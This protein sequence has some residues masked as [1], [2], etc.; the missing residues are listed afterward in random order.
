MSELG[1]RLKNAREEKGYSLDELQVRTKIQ[2]RYLA[3]IEEGDYSRL[4][5]DFYARAFIKSYADAVGLDSEMLFE[6]HRDELPQVKQ[7]PVEIPSRISRSKPKVIKK[8]SKFTSFLP[9]LIVGIFI[10]AIAV[11][12]WYLNQEADNDSSGISRENLQS[13]PN[14]ENA[15]TIDDDVNENEEEEGNQVVDGNKDEENGENQQEE[16]EQ[17]EP[18][19]EYVNTEGSTSYY[20]LS[21]TDTIDVVMNFT[22]QSWVRILDESDSSIH[23]KTYQSGDVETF[24]FSEYGYVRFHLGSTKT[25]N[26]TVNGHLI[27][28]PIDSSVQHIIIDLQQ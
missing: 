11:F 2:T 16:V 15:S 21:N 28:Y 17:V 27:E 1:L 19:L 3:A 4:P 6:E 9:T 14:I 12:I 5:G 24:D 10:I 22:G 25:A 8:K 7:D 20:T 13:D 26:I 18:I 23:E